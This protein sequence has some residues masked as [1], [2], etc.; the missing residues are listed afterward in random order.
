MLEQGAYAVIGGD[1]VER[2]VDRPERESG[3]D[4]VART[5]CRSIVNNADNIERETGNDS[6]LRVL[7]TTVVPFSLCDAI[8]WLLS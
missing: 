8:I 7:K 1:A 5:G 2:A 3:R 6:I 4:P